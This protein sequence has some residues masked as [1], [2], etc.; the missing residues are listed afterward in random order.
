MQTVQRG[1]GAE[2]PEQALLEFFLQNDRQ[3]ATFMETTTEGLS[4][5]D[6]RTV[7]LAILNGFKRLAIQAGEPIPA[8]L[9]D[10]ERRFVAE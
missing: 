4:V 7:A 6:R 2:S 8:T 5:E 1:D 3:L 10:I 9:Y